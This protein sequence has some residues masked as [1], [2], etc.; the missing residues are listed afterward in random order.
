VHV[1]HLHGFER[2]ENGVGRESGRFGFG[3]LLESDL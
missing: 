3:A 2:F 1:D